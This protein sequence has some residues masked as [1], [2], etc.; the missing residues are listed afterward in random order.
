ML[1]IFSAIYINKAFVLIYF[2]TILL[3]IGLDKVLLRNNYGPIEVGE[4]IGLAAFIG[5]STFPNT[6][7]LIAGFLIVLTLVNIIY[8]Y[9][10]SR[11]LKK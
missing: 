8:I 5:K 1:V 4:S 2:I 11:N 7:F 3:L 6:L 10:T 9:I